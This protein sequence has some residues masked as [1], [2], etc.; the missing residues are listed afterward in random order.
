MDHLGPPLPEE[1]RRLDVAE[2]RDDLWLGQVV[3]L[4]HDVRVLLTKLPDELWVNAHDA[5]LHHVLDGPPDPKAVCDVDS[6]VIGATPAEDGDL[7]ALAPAGEARDDGD[8]ALLQGGAELNVEPYPGLVQ[9]DGGLLVVLICDHEVLAVETL[10]L[11]LG[12]SQ[13][14]AQ[15][16]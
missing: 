7:A 3:E 1:L 12:V 5:L 10:V 16:P 4:R 13:V 8:D 9:V 2:V 14:N 15:H 11:N 6:G